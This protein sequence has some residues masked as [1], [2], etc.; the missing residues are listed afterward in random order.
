MVACLLTETIT[1]FDHS[2][3][4]GDQVAFS[5]D[6]LLALNK[7]GSGEDILKKGLSHP[8]PVVAFCKVSSKKKE[9]NRSI[10]L[11]LYFFVK[12]FRAVLNK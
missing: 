3:Y 11:K 7:E 1:S 6:A 12:R 9:L 8:Y 2:A 4:P 10:V 5:R